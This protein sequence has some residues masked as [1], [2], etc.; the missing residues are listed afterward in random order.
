MGRKLYVGNLGYEATDSDLSKMFEPPTYY[1]FNEALERL[2]MQG[3]KL[4]HDSGLREL[5]ATA[6]KT[7]SELDRDLP[8][9]SPAIKGFAQK[10][11]YLRVVMDG[12]DAA[13][14]EPDRDTRERILGELQR[15]VEKHFDKKG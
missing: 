14:A 3:S 15:E 7:F 12:I 10:L 13:L 1:R 8:S 2:R 5:L 6:V 9:N 4:P 11:P